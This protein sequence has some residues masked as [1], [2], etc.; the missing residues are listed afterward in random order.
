MFTSYDF[1]RFSN[2]VYSE[3]VSKKQF[4]NLNIPHPEIIAEDDYGIF[5]KQSK[6]SLR[7]GDIIFTHTGN[8]LNL[9]YLIKNLSKDFEL[10]LITHQSDTPI[11]KKLFSKKPKCV[12]SWYAVNV[13]LEINNLYPIPLGL[14]N[15]A[16][17]DS[18][19]S[20]NNLVYSLN[21]FK[22]NINVYINFNDS[23]NKLERSWI[24]KH[25]EKF[26]WVEIENNKLNIEEYSKKINQSAFVICPW[27]NGIDTHRIWE[28]LLLG[29]IPIVK[30]HTTFKN[31]DDLPIYFVNDL[32]DINKKSLNEFMSSLKSKKLNLKKLDLKYWENIVKSNQNNGQ[33]SINVD[34]PIYV[35]NYFKFQSNVKSF[36]TRKL[37][38]ILYYLKKIR[39]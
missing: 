16:L 37:K 35:S 9:F 11:N 23:T 25:F 38:I 10:I 14:A 36:F 20:R 21:Y 24:K 7:S 4:K 3:V 29:S 1:A 22:E 30:R 26:S 15:D 8:L 12:K 13:D 32:R 2:I 28:T 18:N 39:L 27:G 19:V 34:E 33:L 17:F 5:Y 31:L 6:F